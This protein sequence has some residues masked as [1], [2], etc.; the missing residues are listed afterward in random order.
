EGMRWMWSLGD[1]SLLAE[2]LE[3]HAEALANACEIRPG[4]TVLDVA[5]G[6]GNF[7]LA[8]A[9]LGATVTATDL[10]P[11]MV[12]LGRARTAGVGAITWS[13][14]D[15]EQLPFADS[16]FDVVASVFGAMFAPRPQLVASEMFRVARPGGLVAMANYSP[17]GYLGR[18]S[19]LMATFSAHPAYELPSPFAWGD[20]DELRRRFSGHASSIVVRHR[21]LYFESDSV[22]SFVEFWER[23]NAP[24][25]ALKS[26]L[27]AESYQDVLA[28]QK[29]LVGGLNEASDGGVKLGSP[30][31]LVLAT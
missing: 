2:A 3:P 13:E 4:A 28:Q 14:A 18:M 31:I 5:A 26:M 10:T 12:E 19:D 23:T 1:Y 29:E 30:Y 11:H 15:A 24:L 7:A 16:T 9:R 20:E 25:A 22:E 6:N 17:G 21:T 8:A 27:P